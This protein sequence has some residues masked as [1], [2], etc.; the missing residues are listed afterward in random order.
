[1]TSGLPA[2]DTEQNVLGPEAAMHA[3]SLVLGAD[4]GKRVRVRRQVGHPAIGVTV[5]PLEQPGI[6]E[7][8]RLYLPVRLRSARD[9]QACS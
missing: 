2:P 3:H 1:M 6:G 9:R 4:T 7:E 8:R 5:E